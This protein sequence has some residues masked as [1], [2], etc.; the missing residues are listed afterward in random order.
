MDGWISLHRKIQDHWLWTKKRKFSQFEAWISLLFKASY[1][2][3]QINIDGKIVNLSKGSF[4][5][6]EVKLS[7]EWGWSRETV[8][9]FLK[10]LQEQKMVLK[11]CTSKYTTL[12]IKKWEL[13]QNMTQ[14]IR[15]Q[16]RQVVDSRLDTINK[17]NNINNNLFNFNI[18]NKSDFIGFEEGDVISQWLLTKGISAEDY[19]KLD[20]GTQDDLIEEWF[21]SNR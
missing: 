9:K 11:T 14:Q 2:D 19:K 15:Q 6:S 8:R 20:K 17:V 21:L 1:K 5:T 7:Q 3:T 10:T 4:I 12:T 13:Y 16:N 18:N